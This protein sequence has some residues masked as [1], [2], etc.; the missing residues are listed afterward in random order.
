[1]MGRSA[2]IVMSLLLMTSWLAAQGT[3][4]PAPA[5]ALTN[6][7]G[8]SVSIP[9][10]PQTSKN[11]REIAID[12][13]TIDTREMT[14][15]HDVEYRLYGPGAAHWGS[16][17]FMFACPRGSSQA[18]YA[19]W[20]AGAR[21]R[22][23]RRTV[24][25]SIPKRD[26]TDGRTYTLIDARPVAV[27][28]CDMRAAE[29]IE[30]VTVK[31]S[32]IEFGSANATPPS[33]PRADASFTA[34][35]QG[36]GIRINPDDT[37]DVL[38]GGAR[39]HEELPTALGRVDPAWD[40][41]AHATCTDIVLEGAMTTG[42]QALMQWINETVSGKPSRRTLVVSSP[43]GVTYVYADAFPVRYVFPRLSVTNTT[44]SVREEVRL[45]P[46]RCELK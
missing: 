11:I 2:V 34:T 7:N 15:G 42:R 18:L 38:V 22:N 8:F 39:S 23:D 26:K 27:A 40:L 37:W 13:L 4:V 36:N 10:L 21:T 31:Y 19:W 24:T 43:R 41:G 20:S 1:M 32:R 17:K 16:A 25:V 28:P 9:G 46:I 35:I 5:E 12:E 29:P 6:A 30:E 3:P 45:K 33:K 44:G 14:T